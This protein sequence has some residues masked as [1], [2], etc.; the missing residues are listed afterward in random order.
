MKLFSYR[1]FDLSLVRIEI[2]ERSIEARGRRAVC[3]ESESFGGKGDAKRKQRGFKVGS[4]HAGSI[5][6]KRKHL[7]ANND[8]NKY[9]FDLCLPI[10]DVS[11]KCIIKMFPVVGQSFQ[12]VCYDGFIG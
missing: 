7:E 10:K 3:G 6:T 11:S 12:L 2:S 4:G 8:L 5:E 1:E 9:Y